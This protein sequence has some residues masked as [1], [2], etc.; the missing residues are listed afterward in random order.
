ILKRA[1][2]HFASKGALDI[3]TLGEKNVAVLVDAGLVNDLADIYTLT[4]DD[5]VKLDRFGA[6]SA[7]K[8]VNAI[9]AK[10]QPPLERFIYGL[11]IRHVGIQTAVDLTNTF[12]NLDAL[13]NA[14][15]DQLE[16]VDGVGRVVAESIA[17][18]FADEDNLAL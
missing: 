12:E 8:L 13:A 5:L 10:K 2:E 11:G 3:D 14:R 17:A 18:W 7:E 15:L 4:V 1:L 9:Q 16:S 6:V